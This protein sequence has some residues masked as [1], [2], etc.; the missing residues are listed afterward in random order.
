[1][2]NASS[3]ILKR[4]FIKEDKRVLLIGLDAS[5]KTS[6]LYHMKMGHLTTTLPTIGFNVETLEF[7][8]ISFTCWD[9]GGGGKI[10]PL[11]R[12]YYQNTQAV[13]WVVDSSDRDRI[14]GAGYTAREELHELL[15][16]HE[17]ADA[18]VLILANKQDKPNCMT[19]EEI[20]EKLD[21]SSITSHKW[22]VQP[23]SAK[24]G[25][26]MKEGFDWLHSVLSSQVMPYQLQSI[27]IPQ[28][29][30]RSS[31]SQRRTAP[32]PPV[33]APLPVKHLGVV[34]GVRIHLELDETYLRLFLER[35]LGL[36]S[37]T[38][39]GWIHFESSEKGKEEARAW[40]EQ[41][42]KL[43]MKIPIIG[44]SDDLHESCKT[45]LK[46]L[47]RKDK[48]Y[49]HN[50]S[51]L[52]NGCIE[53]EF[54]HYARLRIMWIF[55]RKFDVR[56]EALERIFNLCEKLEGENYNLTITYFFAHLVHYSIKSQIS[57]IDDFKMFL[58]VNPCMTDENMYQKYYEEGIPESEDAK[59]QMIL[60][61]KKSLPSIVFKPVGDETKA[62]KLMSD[63]E[64][65]DIS[66]EEFIQ[67]FEGGTLS[68]WG[69][70]YFLRTIF[71]YLTSIPRREAVEKCFT[72]FARS[73]GDGY[74]LTLTYFW[75]QL[76]E[77]K[78]YN[79][80]TF[81]DFWSANKAELD[82]QLLWQEYYSHDIIN[83][84]TSASEMK[85]PDKKQLPSVRQ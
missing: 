13:I 21:L 56:R 18:V 17:L 80:A 59:K 52:Q 78:R 82:D 10:K 40:I 85:F 9:V 48:F 51:W 4:F 20:T 75:I 60:P 55:F 35:V 22:H 32:V 63:F 45:M 16:E 1:M 50:I 69:H 76:V 30:S 66:D 2:G 38:A 81:A 49:M 68:G 57:V 37:S 34:P 27:K 77:L 23:C 12:H 33:I 3:H 29:P 47:Q 14:R 15:H 26:G 74:H 62:K 5:G 41:E 54:D 39:R 8:S 72:E 84:P 53:I 36:H 19:V 71:C 31:R 83:D 6:I 79:F 28:I 24:A 61:K 11:W 46:Y 70:E 73:L 65:K 7:K 43:W 67:V 25:V 42:C 64:A 58:M 44:N